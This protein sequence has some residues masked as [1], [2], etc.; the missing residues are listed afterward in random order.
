MS[1]SGGTVEV[2]RADLEHVVACYFDNEDSYEDD[3]VEAD[4]EVMERLRSR[5]GLGS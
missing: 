4:L 1:E 5:L 3:Q 2:S